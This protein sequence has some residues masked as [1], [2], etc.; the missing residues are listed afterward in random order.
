ME[1]AL[2]GINWMPVEL[3]AYGGGDCTR[4]WDAMEAAIGCGDGMTMEAGI[5]CL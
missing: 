2:G 3:D 1:V 4:R 5:G